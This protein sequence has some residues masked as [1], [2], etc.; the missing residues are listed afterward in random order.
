[1]PRSGR[2][3]ILCL[4]GCAAAFGQQD[5]RGIYIYTEHLAQDAALVT[6]ALGV[7]GVDGLTL[8]LGWASLEPNQGVY[9]WT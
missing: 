5:P 4:I 2:W 9:Q 7:P 3:G 8:L 6:Q 1:M